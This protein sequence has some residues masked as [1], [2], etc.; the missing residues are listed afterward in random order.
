MK[1]TNDKKNKHQEVSIIPGTIT[2]VSWKKMKN[3]TH[4]LLGHWMDDGCGNLILASTFSFGGSID[5]KT[6]KIRLIKQ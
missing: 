5:Y 3:G 2:I 1:S 6:G 4:K